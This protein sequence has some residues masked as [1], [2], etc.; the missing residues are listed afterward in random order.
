MGNG[1]VKNKHMGV[2]YSPYKIP[3]FGKRNKTMSYDSK[4]DTLE[5][6]RK[7]ANLMI[8]FATG[9]LDRARIHDDSKLVE[10][11]KSVFDVVT[12]R[13]AG[14]TYGS[15]EYKASLKEMGPALEH[16]YKNNRH[17]P[18]Y[19]KDGI[20]GMSLMDLVEMLLDWKAAT[21]R[22]DDGDIFKSIEINV[23]RF[24]IDDQLA[25]ILRNTAE[26]MFRGEYNWRE[27]EAARV[28]HVPID[29]EA[30]VERS[31]E[32]PV[33]IDFYL[34][35]CGPC[36]K[37]EPRLEQLAEERGFELVKVNCDFE[38]RLADKFHVKGVPHLVMY[39]KGNMV[40]DGGG[41][42]AVT[43]ALD[44]INSAV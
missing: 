29:F 42:N 19:H 13:L 26:S 41:I 5:H 27:R 3:F 14:L 9:L 20:N 7:V 39:H 12:P 36:K 43:L 16:H 11:E 1:E 34:D 4:A 17:H 23:K 21:E 31:K 28:K 32:K 33:L 8:R 18:E 37:L 44:R 38:R 24:N 30:L 40:F 25:S 6:I 35:T 10:P 2:W 22:H 15:D